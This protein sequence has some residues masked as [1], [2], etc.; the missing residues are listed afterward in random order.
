[1]T[2]LQDYLKVDIDFLKDYIE[3]YNSNLFIKKN[4]EVVDFILKYY[5]EKSYKFIPEFN[6]EYNDENYTSQLTSFSVFNEKGKE[7]VILEHDED[8][9]GDDFCNVT[10]KALEGIESVQ[11][12][13]EYFERMPQTFYIKKIELPDLYVKE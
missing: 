11:D 2:K 8:E 4:K 3:K 6:N 7:L 9:Y 13:S 5:G 1:M 12:V 10:D